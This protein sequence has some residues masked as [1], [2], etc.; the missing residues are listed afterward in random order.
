MIRFDR[1]LML[2]VFFWGVQHIILTRLRVWGDDFYWVSAVWGD[3]QKLVSSSEDFGK[4]A[5]HRVANFRHIQN[6]WHT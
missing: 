1:V 4:P 6:V 3:A 2:M 5:G